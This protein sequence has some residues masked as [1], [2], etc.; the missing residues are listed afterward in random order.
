MTISR[1][2]VYLYNPK[3]AISQSYI[4][5]WLTSNI[6]MGDA[7]RRI[8]YEWFVRQKRRLEG[9]YPG[10]AHLNN[11]I[12]PKVR[13]IN[14]KKYYFQKKIRQSFQPRLHWQRFPALCS[15]D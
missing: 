10:A 13:E 5:Q 15:R 1:S 12:N 4:S 8:I 2:H 6:T 11:T 14:L 7:K 9:V 3:K